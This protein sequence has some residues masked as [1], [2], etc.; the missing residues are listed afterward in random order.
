LPVK[1]SLIKKPIGLSFTFYSLGNGP[2]ISSIPAALGR[3]QWLQL[4]EGEYRHVSP[5]AGT[6]SAGLMPSA[7]TL[8]TDELELVF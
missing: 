2:W 3:P 4:Y 8:F 1:Q 6:T 5:S 7:A